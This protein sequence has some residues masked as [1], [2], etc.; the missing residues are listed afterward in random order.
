MSA[1]FSFG[2]IGVDLA[3]SF[4]E[5]AEPAPAPR[6]QSS[7]PFRMLVIGDFSGRANRGV[8]ESGTEIAKRKPIA[9]DR[10][11]FDE[12]LARL[13]P[14]LDLELVSD[15]GAA[16]VH[17]EFADLDDFHPDRL[18][19]KAEIF[20]RL[21]QLRRRLQDPK[22][23][24]EAAGEL[25]P[26]KAASPSTARPA[27]SP[28]PAPDKRTTSSS[29]GDN[30]LGSLLEATEQA[31]NTP[32][33]AA[34]K[35]SGP[36]DA[37]IRSIAAPYALAKPDP[38]LKELLGIVDAATSETL[39]RLLH[40]PT[41]QA[42]EAA[43]RALFLLVRRL[44]T[45]AQLQL[46]VLDLSRAEIAADLAAQD[47]LSHSGLYRLLVEQTINT[48]GVQPWA[49]LVGNFTF[50]HTVE[51][52]ELLGRLAQIAAAAGA[53][54]LAAGHSRL[55]GCESFAD[56]P[57]PADWKKTT[58]EAA[59][60]WQALRAMPAA[61][62]VSLAM[63]RFLVRVPYGPRTSPIQPFAF[64]EIAGRPAHEDLLW[65][66]SAFLCALALG[67]AFARDGWNMRPEQGRE[68]G[69]LPLYT[70]KEDGETVVYP[71]A[72]A[73][74]SDRAADRLGEA[75]VSSVQSIRGR[76]AVLMRHL[77]LG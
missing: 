24:A 63:P 39:R 16:S 54:F 43:W 38:E 51:D 58:G 8:K 72:E 71:C 22:T 25:R 12:V 64:E 23:F 52:A 45:D 31:A 5:G 10:D 27:D 2:K 60:A 9:I 75:G 26:A 48:P 76:D 28:A 69:D 40:A 41:F 70:Y 57:D 20:A 62:R 17:L 33:A 53:P 30:L 73:L 29:L 13:A 14:Q 50:D 11:N 1:K 55:V 44:D 35:A 68:I 3:A 18:V 6:P 46:Y 65:A 66:N 36:W 56:T 74:L 15:E 4:E 77:R 21:R 42:L 47:D 32:S 49:A 59:E 37:L 7:R 34:P 67:E 61:K 19:P